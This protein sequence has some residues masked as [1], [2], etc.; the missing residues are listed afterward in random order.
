MPGTANF[1]TR[2][3]R[4]AN[5]AAL[6]E[7]LAQEIA[8]TLQDGLARGRGA[9]LAVPGG[10]TPIALFERLSSATLDW[11][12]VWVTLTDERWVDAA[13]ASSNE[14]LV[15]DHLL[16]GAAAEA[17][18]VGLKNAAGEAQSGAH[19]SWSTVA[20]LPRPF[21]FMLLGMGEDGHIASLFPDSP[22][23]AVALDLAQPPGCVA[24]TAPEPPRARISLN[25]RALLDSRRI[26]ILIVGN[27]KWAT[28]ERAR[29]RGPAVDMPVRA[30]LQQQNVPVSVYWS[31]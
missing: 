26:A 9:S 8:G 6:T 10:R 20:E 11:D 12:D 21:D 14:K 5:V 27:A 24:M 4:F 16:R 1:D 31:P 28:F 29:V 22:G 3:H 18:F 15:R 25:L 13:S 30:L 17:H 23:L 2:E 19:L 7:A